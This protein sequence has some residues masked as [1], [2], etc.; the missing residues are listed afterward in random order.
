MPWHELWAR[1]TRHGERQAR[2][3]SE[4]KKAQFRQQ[5]AARRQRERGHR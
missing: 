1:F 4:Q 3:A 5:A 2:K